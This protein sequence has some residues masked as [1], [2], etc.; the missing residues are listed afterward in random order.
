[1]ESKYTDDFLLSRIFT[2]LTNNSKKII[3]A[4]VIERKNRKML[5]TNFLSFCNSIDRSSTFIA[6]FIE[7]ELK[8]KT[9][10]ASGMLII[11]TD[12]GNV[13]FI[14]KTLFKYVEKYVKCSEQNCKSNNTSIIKDN[15]LQ[16]L[17]CN[18]CLSRKVLD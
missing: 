13:D 2:N 7:Q 4:P 1:M 14:N 12:Y 11:N 5:I 17:E 3:V 10:I 8:T 6:S 15:K 18:V 16:Y 9:S